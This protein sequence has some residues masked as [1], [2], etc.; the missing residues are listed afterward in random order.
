MQIRTSAAVAAVLLGTLLPAQETPKP[1]LPTPP[2]QEPK[3]AAQQPKETPKVLELGAVV[4]KETK[5]TDLEGK[6]FTFGELRGKTVV[7]HFWSITCPWEKAAEP[8]LMKIASDY[9]D[10]DVVVLA[11]NS[12]QNEIGKQP[13]AAAFQAKEAKERPYADIRAH[14]D[15]VEFNHKILVDHGGDV[16]HYFAAKTTPHCFV[17]DTTGKLVYTGALDNDGRDTLGDKA[18]RYVRDAVD[19]VLAGK[20]VETDTTKPYG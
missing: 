5:L 12:N 8:K 19:A 17:L 2:P 13:E 3:A 16:A 9:A 14:A 7:I 18:K 20:K 11:I 4:P 10:K 1:V 6:E 15:E